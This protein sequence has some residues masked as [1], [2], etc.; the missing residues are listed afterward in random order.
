MNIP[1]FIKLI[2]DI[3]G[4]KSALYLNVENIA[5]YYTTLRGTTCVEMNSSRTPSI[6]Y[7]DESVSRIT[8]LIEEVCNLS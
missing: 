8:E 2:S 6:F 4:N 1:P 7:V 3:D 5:C